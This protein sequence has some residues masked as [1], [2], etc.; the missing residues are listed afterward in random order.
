VSITKHRIDIVL[1][2]T[3][4]SIYIPPKHHT[5]KDNSF[6]LY[7]PKI[8]IYIDTEIPWDKK[9]IDQVLDKFISDDVIMSIPAGSNF[10]NHSEKDGDD[11]FSSVFVMHVPSKTLHVGKF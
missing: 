9:T 10:I 8:L 7:H 2:S 5:N 1:L 6:I 4:F 3:L 11:H